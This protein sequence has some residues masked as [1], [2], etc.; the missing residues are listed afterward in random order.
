MHSIVIYNFQNTNSN[1]AHV[2]NSDLIYRIYLHSKFFMYFYFFPIFFL[3]FLLRETSKTEN[4]N[5][6]S[7]ESNKIKDLLSL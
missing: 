3:F 6:K 1:I 4:V 2:V 5:L 7:H